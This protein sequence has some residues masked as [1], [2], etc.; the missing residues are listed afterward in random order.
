M[1]FEDFKMLQYVNYS[2]LHT[3]K[4]PYQCPRPEYVMKFLENNGKNLKK[5]HTDEN[6][7]ALSLSIPNYCPNLKSLFV[8]I[9]SDELDIL[10]TI[11]INCQYLESI[12][13][14]CGKG[15]F[16]SYLSEKEIFETV[17]NHS[18][19]NFCELKIYNV[20]KSDVSLED[21]KSFFTSWKNR[22]P[23]KLLSLIIIENNCISL[24]DYEENMKIIEE[25]ENLGII[26]FGTIGYDE[27]D[28]EEEEAYYYY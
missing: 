7:K 18:Q 20:S 24:D 22:I 8:I 2:K 28:K 5:F 3:L 11:F 1:H 21:L 13:V 27:E 25:Y 12:K 19:N 4:I 23:K 16:G 26:K 6:D 14:W 17:I 15:Y 10:K 9:N